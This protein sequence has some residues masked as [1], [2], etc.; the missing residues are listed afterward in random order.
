MFFEI[1]L[2][3][4]SGTPTEQLSRIHS[5]LY[6]LHECLDLQMQN[7]DKLI[8]QSQTDVQKVI[9]GT[10]NGTQAYRFG[11]SGSWRWRAWSNGFIEMWY[12]G[13]ATSTPGTVAMYKEG[14]F[15]LVNGDDTHISMPFVP[16]EVYTVMGSANGSIKPVITS[17]FYVAAG[18]NPPYVGYRLWALEHWDVSVDVRTS[19][20]ITGHVDDYLSV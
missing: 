9:E 10:K 11:T 12:A 2:P 4:A 8:R 1:D 3:S 15:W 20:Y 5:Y 7:I 18:A 19:L 6:Q 16:D 17:H 14:P 13:S